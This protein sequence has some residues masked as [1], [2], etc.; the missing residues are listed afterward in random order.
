MINTE[1]REDL[2]SRLLTIL[3]GKRQGQLGE[4]LVHRHVHLRGKVVREQHGQ[5]HQDVVVD[6]L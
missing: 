1:N 4:E 6:D 5:H 2:S 3:L